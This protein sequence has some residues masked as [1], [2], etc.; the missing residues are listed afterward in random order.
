MKLLAPLPLLLLASIAHG[1]QSFEDRVERANYLEKTAEGREY[2]D[3]MW[4]LVGPVL[5][6]VTNRCVSEDPALEGQTLT[7]VVTVSV[8][9]TP[10]D[11]EVQ[12]RTKEAQCIAN[13]IA[14]A[15]FPKPPQTFSAG[16][17]PLVFVL[18]LH[19]HKP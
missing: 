19:T 14:R 5:A 12:P 8:D 1:G 11:I 6:E 10:R 9:G 13:E 18:H 7:L 2:Q 4:P 15:P 16:G 17:L 3:T